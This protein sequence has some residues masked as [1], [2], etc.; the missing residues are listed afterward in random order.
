MI[1]RVMSDIFWIGR[2]TERADYH[3]RLINANLQSYQE[4]SGFEA[5]RLRLWQNLLSALGQAADYSSRYAEP[6]E[7]SVLHYLTLDESHDNSIISCLAAARSNARAVRERIPGFLWEAINATHV[8]LHHKDIA[9]V[10]ARSPY[11]FYQRIKER[12]AL[13][14]GIADSAML[15]RGEWHVL[16]CGRYI[17]RAENTVRLLQML[18]GAMESAPEDSPAR[19]QSLLTTLHTVDGVE[20]FRK[21][22]AA[23]VSLENV[24][25]LL[26]LNAEFP[27]AAFFALNAAEFN[28]K[29]M[30]KLDGSAN[31]NMSRVN[32]I[33]KRTQAL[34][35]GIDEESPLAGDAEVFLQTLLSSCNQLSLEFFHILSCQEETAP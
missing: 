8:S 21:L 35:M 15:R 34:V 3:A 10:Y 16:Q 28:I 13:F 25:R 29:L 18:L 9:S 23:D 14:Y 32:R 11:L 5:E 7:K 27:R 20:A 12:V 26:L 31:V 30:Q 24:Y 22:Y 33:L 19:Y 6:G 2:Y 17:E 4:I 1:S